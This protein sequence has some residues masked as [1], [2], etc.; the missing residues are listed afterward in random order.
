[1]TFAKLVTTVVTAYVWAS[2][3]YD[4]GVSVTS[5]A[6][7]CKWQGGVCNVSGDVNI[8]W[9]SCTCG[10]INECLNTINLYDM[11]LV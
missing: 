11:R 8:A 3:T 9:G 4:N 5:I 1:M 7:C 6:K 2:T 10:M